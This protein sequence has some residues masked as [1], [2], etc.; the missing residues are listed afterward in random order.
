MSQGTM[1][2][3]TI[4][5]DE[6]PA[7]ESFTE[8]E[9][10]D[11]LRRRPDFF[12]R[13]LPLL[14]RL[15]LPHPSGRSTI[16]LVERQVSMLRQRNN[17]LERQLKDLVAVAKANNALVDNIHHLSVQMM[18]SPDH[19]ALLEILE[20]SLREDFAAERAVLILFNGELEVAAARSG[21]VKQ[22]ERTDAA[23][24]PFVTFFR[25]ARP[26]CG[27]LRDRQKSVL[28]DREADSIVS[29]ALVPIGAQARLGFL[30]IG[31]RDSEQFTPA[32]SVDFLARLGEL[33][34]V[35]LERKHDGTRRQ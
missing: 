5:Q 19:E 3:G 17:E 27:M 24:K 22:Y 23:L 30:A 14:L 16:S 28:F 11:Y 13:H 33:V 34:A 8:A 32:Q 35:A 29:A 15:K 7:E 6:T 9:I 18:R 26:R 21:F 2:P 10:A 20:S 4:S 25:S 1:S 31:S 12:E